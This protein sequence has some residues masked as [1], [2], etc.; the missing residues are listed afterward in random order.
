MSDSP[1]LPKLKPL[2][3]QE[4]RRPKKQP[5]ISSDVAAF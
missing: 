2:P 5:S 1:N 3:M 4:G